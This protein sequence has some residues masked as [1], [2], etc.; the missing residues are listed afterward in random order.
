MNNIGA[1]ALV[2][3]VAFSLTRS[4]GIGAAGGADAALVRDAA[5]GAL[6]AVGTP[7][8]LVVSD[9]LRDATGAG[10]GFLDFAPTGLAVALAGL[11]AIVLWAPRGAG[12]GTAARERRRG[13]AGS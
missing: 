8:N 10:F 9:A 3:P 7:A 1:F 5:R 4:A 11:A 6:H 2:L 12:C 13:R